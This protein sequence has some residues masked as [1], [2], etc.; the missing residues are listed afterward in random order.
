MNNQC[1]A[2]AGRPLER[3]GSILDTIHSDK[4]VYLQPA[5]HLVNKACQ[6]LD[7]RLFPHGAAGMAITAGHGAM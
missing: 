7:V 3:R 1:L 6:S 5:G 4:S 2:E